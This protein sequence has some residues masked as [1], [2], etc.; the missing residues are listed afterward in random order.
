MEKEKHNDSKN[1]EKKTDIEE[2]NEVEKFKKGK[3]S[4]VLLFFFG[5]SIITF[6]IGNGFILKLLSFIQAVLFIVSWLMGMQIIKEKFKDL[7]I[8]LAIV[9]FVLIVPILGNI[10]SKNN[11]Y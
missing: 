9:A 3:F 4:K 6:F 2:L 5:I 1:I 8:I 11:N 10:G 7:K